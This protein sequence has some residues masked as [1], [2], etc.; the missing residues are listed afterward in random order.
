[1]IEKS[2]KIAKRLT[3]YVDK[4]IHGPKFQSHLFQTTLQPDKPRPDLLKKQ[5]VHQY[6]KITCSCCL[7]RIHHNEEVFRCEAHHYHEKHGH[8]THGGRCLACIVNCRANPCGEIINCE[9]LRK[10][11]AYM[12]D[13][14][15]QDRRT[16]IRNWLRMNDEESE[17]RRDPH[18]RRAV[19]VRKKGPKPN[20]AE[21]RVIIVRA[22]SPVMPN[23]RTRKPNAIPV[24]QPQPVSNSST[25]PEETPSTIPN[26]RTRNGNGPFEAPVAQSQQ[27]I[28]NLYN[29]GTPSDPP[30]TLKEPSRGAVPT[31]TASQVQQDISN[32]HAPNFSSAVASK[33]HS[34]D[35]V[36][37]S[38]SS[39]AQRDIDSQQPSKVPDG[40]S[41]ASRQILRAFEATAQHQQSNKET[42]ETNKTP[43]HSRPYKPTPVPQQEAR[44]ER[45]NDQE[46]PRAPNEPSPEHIAV[47]RDEQFNEKPE[48]IKQ[49]GQSCAHMTA[50]S[51]Q[52]QPELENTTQGSANSQAGKLSEHIAAQATRHHQ[53]NR[54][55]EPIVQSKP[56]PVPHKSTRPDI[57]A[58]VSRPD[59]QVVDI[60]R[61]RG[62][63]TRETDR[64]IFRI[65]NRM[66]LP[67]TK[68]IRTDSS[69]EP[70]QDTEE[71]SSMSIVHLWGGWTPSFPTPLADSDPYDSELRA[72]GFEGEGRSSCSPVDKGTVDPKQTKVD[73]GKAKME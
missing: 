49:E 3:L 50:S 20:K 73:K 30:V 51:S 45:D 59:D 36:S 23:R 9:Y 40:K 8:S 25:L 71:G 41:R 53:L 32:R 60:Y 67:E 72:D 58:T 52:P 31:T 37:P 16:Y 47:A 10:A 18:D 17:W 64:S 7:I 39:Q 66:H 70:K 19:R 56:P 14:V 57:V 29:S 2:V 28:I 15:K 13:R 11:E 54:H 68:R 55:S 34:R 35:P 1:M 65:R 12:Q 21:P 42:G 26:E 63:L 43:G 33:E 44:P 61:I 27:V 62:I 24:A 6:S 69:N 48:L 46:P 5:R 38:S 22:E 4:L